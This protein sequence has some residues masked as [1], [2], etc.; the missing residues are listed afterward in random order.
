MTESLPRNADDYY[1]TPQMSASDQGKPY[2]AVEAGG[3]FN[4]WYVADRRGSNVLRFVE[5]PG[6]MF[7]DEIEAKRIAE[8]WN[9]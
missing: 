5:K 1:L 2:K 7:T 3:V 6:A 9:Q 4:W 8:R